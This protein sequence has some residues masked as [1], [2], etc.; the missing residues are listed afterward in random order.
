MREPIVVP[1]CLNLLPRDGSAV[2]L[3]PT[4]KSSNIGTIAVKVFANKDRPSYT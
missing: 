1:A 2:V 4:F 3:E